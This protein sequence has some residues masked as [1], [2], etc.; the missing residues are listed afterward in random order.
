MG[1]KQRS[2]TASDQRTNCSGNTGSPTLPLPPARGHGMTPGQESV[3]GKVRND[4]AQLWPVV[5]HKMFSG[6][7]VV[8]K[9]FA[10][11]TFKCKLAVIISPVTEMSLNHTRWKRNASLLHIYLCTY[12][13]THTV[14][15]NAGVFFSAGALCLLHQWRLANRV[16]AAEGTRGQR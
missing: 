8:K 9:C 14:R 16:N 4:T 2:G 12:L 11:Q 1:S 15:N 7:V 10:F 13:L 5:I 6:Q 3:T